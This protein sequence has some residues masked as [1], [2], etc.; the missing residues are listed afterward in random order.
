MAVEVAGAAWRVV[1]VA[2]TVYFCSEGCRDRFVREPGQFG[3][4]A[5]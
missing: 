5:G 1:H 3:A 2:G 4:A